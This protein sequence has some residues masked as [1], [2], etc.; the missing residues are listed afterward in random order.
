MC[1]REERDAHV[2]DLA[3]E[4]FLRQVVLAVVVEND[5]YFLVAQAAYVWA[6][7]D[8]VG[9]FAVHLVLVQVAS[10][11]LYVS[12]AAVEALFVFDAELYDE[13]LSLVAE[14]TIKFGRNPVEF[15]VLCCLQTYSWHIHKVYIYLTHDRPTESDKGQ[16]LLGVRG[17]MQLFVK[18]WRPSSSEK[19]S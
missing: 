4:L 9:R 6:E 1:H 2:A 7:H 17:V 10:E 11:Q 14:W 5:V 18:V 19:S 8:Q 3:S 16:V 13:S 12:T 15:Q